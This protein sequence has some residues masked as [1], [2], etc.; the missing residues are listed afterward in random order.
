MR[1]S[2]MRANS[3]G[4]YIQGNGLGGSAAASIER[5]EMS[6][7][8]NVGL[9]VDGIAGPAVARY[10]DCVITGNVTGLA[11]SNGGQIITFRTNMLAG[12]TT[13]GSTP[14]SISLK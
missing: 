2:A 7:N 9:N 1:D 12:N 5:S 6:F 11:A 13:D 10:S 4:I 8:A 14:F 3:S